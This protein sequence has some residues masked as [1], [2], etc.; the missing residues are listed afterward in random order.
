MISTKGAMIYIDGKESNF[1]IHEFVC[2]EI[3]ERW[4][5]K[6]S[7]R[8]I[9]EAIILAAQY[10][11]DKTGLGVTINDYAYGGQYRDSGTRSPESYG[12]MYGTSKGLD[13]YL[14]TYSMHK[15]CAAADLK[16]G[17]KGNYMSSEDM[18]EFVLDNESDL[19]AIGIRRIENPKF[20]VS[21]HGKKGK[22]WLHID[23]GNS[24]SEFIIQ[25]NP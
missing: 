5:N 24:A 19:M 2:P 10:I 7:L 16:I 21:K 25:V 3:Y 6:Q 9:D 1:D 14:I 8:Y 15:F 18:A 11:R 22:D 23:T 17:S 12:R 20:T 4:G 13:K